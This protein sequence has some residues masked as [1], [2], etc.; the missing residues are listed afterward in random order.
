MSDK[1]FDK[2]LWP[3]FTPDLFWALSDNI[4]KCAI[5]KSI[6]EDFVEYDIQTSDLPDGKAGLWRFNALRDIRV[7]LDNWPSKLRSKIHS[8][9]LC[10]GDKALEEV[11]RTP[12]N[13][14][15]YEDLKFSMFTDDSIL[16]LFVVDDNSLTVRL[17]FRPSLTDN[18]R[19]LVPTK[20][21]DACGL[22]VKI[23]DQKRPFFVAGCSD[24][25]L[26]WD[27]QQSRIV[28]KHLIRAETFDTDSES[29]ESA[30]S[31]EFRSEFPPLID[32]AARWKVI[33]NDSATFEDM[34]S[35]LQTENKSDDRQDL[36]ELH[37]EDL[38]PDLHRQLQTE[39][40]LKMQSEP[41]V[42]S[43]LEKIV[44]KTTFFMPTPR[45]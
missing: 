34:W 44:N 12:H 8:A 27:G 37:H 31:G 4:S 21:I 15:E 42:D 20:A 33:N 22:L 10:L 39:L 36:R 30:S 9:T 35:S 3:C 19:L 1:I 18:E 32:S 28:S 29:S 16:P 11:I 40:D 24:S 41:S 26:S 5:V 38:T 23:K 43:E 13:A 6:E 7:S 2:S 45:N 14:Y 17:M 25:I